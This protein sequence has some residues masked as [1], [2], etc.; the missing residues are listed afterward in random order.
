MSDS[1]FDVIVIGAGITGLT[2]AKHAVQQG[3]STANIEALLFGGLVININELDGE[4]HG[5]GTELASNLMLEV[6]DLGV[7]NIA[8]TVTALAREGDFLSVVTDA[9]QHRAR[10][11]IIA[12]G[13]GGGGRGGR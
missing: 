1:N 8:E 4:P 13:G 3:L 7:A 5:S 10:A 9:G 12:S 2:A 6:S 11:V